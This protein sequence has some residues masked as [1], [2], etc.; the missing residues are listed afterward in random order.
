[1]KEDHRPPLVGPREVLDLSKKRSGLDNCI[2]LRDR[3]LI[4]WLIWGLG[5]Y[6]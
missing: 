3:D 4:P 1:M 5:V 2:K 6:F